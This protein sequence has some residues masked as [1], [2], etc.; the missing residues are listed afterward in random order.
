VAG[1]NGLVGGALPRK[2]GGREWESNPRR[3]AC[4]PYRV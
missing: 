2:N 4:G 1:M 3:T